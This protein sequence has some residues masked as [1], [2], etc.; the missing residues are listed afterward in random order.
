GLHGPG[1]DHTRTLVRVGSTVIIVDTLQ[2]REAVART[3]YTA[4]LYFHTPVAPGIAVAEGSQVRL[5]DAARFVRVFEVLD[6][7]RAEVDLIDNPGDLAAGYAPGYGE[8]VTGTTIRVTIPVQ[9]M[10]ALVCVVRSPEV[11][12]TMTRSRVGEIGCA[13]TENHV[14]RLVSLRLDPFGVFVGGR[15]IVGASA[16]TR[17]RTSA[18]A[19]DS[20]EWLDEI[21]A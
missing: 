4:T 11:S 15:A 18:N 16:T 21:D 3:A 5:T 2:P 17:S 13:I 20:L 1:V 6:E 7:P 12:V 8:L 14:R 19:N 10:L 9:E